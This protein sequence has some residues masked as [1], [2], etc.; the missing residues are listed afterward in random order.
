MPLEITFTGFESTKEN[1][2]LNPCVKIQ[3]PDRDLNI[4]CVWCLSWGTKNPWVKEINALIKWR[5][6]PSSR[7]NNR[8]ITLTKHI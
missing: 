4:I 7:E 1:I 8:K 3:N 5:P 2:A 6:P